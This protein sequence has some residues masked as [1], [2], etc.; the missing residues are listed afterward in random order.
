M[1]SKY[2]LSQ[3]TQISVTEEPADTTNP[4]A[5]TWIDFNCTMGEISYTGGQKSD[6]EVTTLCS[7][8]QEMTNGLAAP[9]EITLS[10]NWVI[11]DEG[12]KVMR[13]AYKDDTIHAFRI[14]FP[15]GKGYVFL[16]EVRQVSFTVSTSAVISGSFTLRLKGDIEEYTA[17]E[18]VAP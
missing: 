15:S 2:E 14:V 17:Q 4:A 3:G 10:G 5:A 8:E 13:Q 16:A 7:I 11:D 6:I 12:Q 1:A 9:A 18:E